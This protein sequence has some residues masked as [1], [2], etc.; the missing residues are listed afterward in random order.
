MM[1]YDVSSIRLLNDTG[2]SSTDK[3][4]YDPTLTGTVSSGTG[5]SSGMSGGYGGFG[6]LH[7]QFDHNGD[8][9]GDGSVIVNGTSFQYDPRTTDPGLYFYAGSVNFKQRV[10]E[11]NYYNQLVSTGPW[12]D[13]G[14]TLET[15]ASGEIQLRDNN[16]NILV[17]Q[18]NFNF[19]SVEVG[20]TL[21]RTFTIDNL[22]SPMDPAAILRLKTND[23]Q[24]PPGYSITKAYASTVSPGQQTSFTI[25]V[26]TSTAGPKWGT[27]S[28]K[29][30]DG[31]ENP[32]T[33]K[34]TADVLSRDPEIDIQLASSGQ[35]IVD[36]TGSLSFGSTEIGTPVQRQIRI[37]NQGNSPLSLGVPSVGSGFSITSFVPSS[38]PANSSVLVTLQM[39]AGAIGSLDVP[40][41]IT[42]NDSDENPYNFSLK[43]TITNV[44]PP[45]VDNFALLQDNGVSATDRITTDPRLSGTVRGAFQGGTVRVEFDHYRTGNINGSLSISNSGDSFT[46]DPRTTDNRLADVSGR[47]TL[48]YRVVHLNAQ[49]ETISTGNWVDFSLVLDGIASTAGLTLNNFGLVRDTGSSLIDRTTTDPT[50]R[51]TLSGDRAGGKVRLEFDQQ[52]NGTVTKYVEFPADSNQVQ[53]DPRSGDPSLIGR[54]GPVDLRYRLTKLDAVGNTLSSS[55]WINF[56]YQLDTLP[57]SKVEVRNLRL[58]NDT[59]TSATDRITS[60]PTL[61]GNLFDTAATPIDTTYT[62]V[63]FD[64]NGDG[65]VDG[66]VL[67]DNLS[68]FTYRPQGLSYNSHTLRVRSAS[69]RVEFASYLLGPWSEI[70][71]QLFAPPAPVIESLALVSDTGVSSTDKITDNP[72]IVGTVKLEERPVSD[73]LVYIDHDGNG[74]SEGTAIT[75]RFG[76]FTYRPRNLKPGAVQLTLTT[77]YWDSNLNSTVYAKP[78]QFQYTY[79]AT[80]LPKIDWLD[81]AIDDGSDRLDRSTSQSL[82]VGQ[83]STSAIYA[84]VQIEFD[85]DNNGS[86]DGVGFSDAAG[87][88]VYRPF[89]LAP[90]A[91]TLKARTKVWDIDQVQWV[92]GDWSQTQFTLVAS[93]SSSLAI[94][95]LALRR[96]TGSNTSDRITSEATLVGQIRQSNSTAAVSVF[97]LANKRVEFDENGDDQVDGYTFTEDNGKFTYTPKSLSSGAKSFRART[98][99]WNTVSNQGELS[100]WSTFAF[101]LQPDS[102]VAP[103]V[104]SLALLSDSGTSATDRITRHPGLLGTVQLPPGATTAMLEV[105]LNSDGIADFL[106]TTQADGTFLVQPNY[107]TF[108]PKTVAVR[109]FVDSSSSTSRVYSPWQSFNY[110]YSDLPSEPASLTQLAWT[111]ATLKNSPILT[112]KVIDDSSVANVK[113][114]IDLNNDGVAEAVVTTDAQGKFQYNY[115]PASSAAQ[116]SV[117]L[118]LR[119]VQAIDGQA[120]QISA[121]STQ[122]FANPAPTPPSPATLGSWGLA[123]DDG[124]SSTDRISTD[125]T[126]RGTINAG[127]NAGSIAEQLI[128][129][130]HDGDGKPDGSTLTDTQGKFTYP[131]NLA[132]G[133][134]NIATRLVSFDPDLGLITGAW[135]QLVV[136]QS[137]LVETKIATL[138]LVSDTGTVNDG[139]TANPAVQGTLTGPSVAQV[140]I[141]VD[142]NGD[143]SPDGQTTTNAAG[144]FSYTPAT[145]SAEGFVQATAWIARGGSPT[146]STAKTYRFVYSPAPNGNSAQALV[147]QL[148]SFDSAWQS[149]NTTLQQSL[150]AAQKSLRSSL[151]TADATYRT[152]VSAAY[153]L[154]QS[155]R[156]STLSAYRDSL[157]SAEFQLGTA[158]SSAEAT[159][160]NQTSGQTSGTDPLFV[161]PITPPEDALVIPND[162]DQPAPPQYIGIDAGQTLDV[163]SHPS[164]TQLYAIADSR[165]TTAYAAAEAAYQ[166]RLAQA[167]GKAAQSQGTAFQRF[168]SSVA[169]ARNIK[170]SATQNLQHPDIDLAAASR[171]SATQAQAKQDTKSAAAIAAEKQFTDTAVTLNY[172]RTD[173]INLAQ[174]DRESRIRAAWNAFN[175]DFMYSYGNSSMLQMLTKRRDDALQ[176]AHRIYIRTLADAEYDYTTKLAEAT[177]TRDVSIATSGYDYESAAASFSKLV[178]DLVAVVEHWKQ[179]QK[180]LAA[181]NEQKEIALAAES[182]ALAEA[183]TK[184]NSAVAQIEAAYERQ[185]SEIAADEENVKTKGAVAVSL[186]T[187]FAKFVDSPAA[188]LQLSYAEADR[189][190][191]DS[192]AGSKAQRD[193]KT[194]TEKRDAALYAASQAKQH[195]YRVAEANRVEAMATADKQKQLRTEANDAFKQLDLDR[196]LTT[197]NQQV[198]DATNKRDHA[199]NLANAS[200][201]FT[202]AAAVQKKAYSYALAAPAAFSLVFPYDKSSYYGQASAQATYQFE[203]AMIEVDRN[204]RYAQANN[205]FDQIAKQARS[206]AL[207]T[208]EN[209]TQDHNTRALLIQYSTTYDKLIAD[210]VAAR[211]N[212][213]TTSAT[214][215]NRNVLT[216]LDGT[217]QEIS[218]LD[219]TYSTEVAQADR[220][221]NLSKV[222]AKATKTVETYQTYRD[223]TRSFATSLGTPWGNLHLKQAEAQTQRQTLQ[224]DA[225]LTQTQEDNRSLETLTNQFLQ[226]TKSLID[227]QQSGTLGF[228]SS[229]LGSLADY[230]S[231]TNRESSSFFG[232]QATLN[233]TF[234]IAI[235]QAYAVWKSRLAEIR[236]DKTI[237]DAAAQ[238]AYLLKDADAKATVEPAYAAARR[239]WAIA[240]A[241]YSANEIN[242]TQWQQAKTAY[243][244]AIAAADRQLA[245]LLAPE[246]LAKRTS[247]G[248]AIRVR[249][250]DT[251]KAEETW[252]KSTTTAY[253][254]WVKNSGTQTTTTAT[255]FQNLGSTFVTS[256][257]QQSVTTST[258]LENAEKAFVQSTSS[259]QATW[260]TQLT[261]NANTFQTAQAGIEGDWLIGKIDARADYEQTLANNHFQRKELVYQNS[262]SDLALLQKAVAQGDA[263]KYTQRRTAYQARATAWKSHALSLTTTLNTTDATWIDSSTTTDLALVRGSTNATAQ[264]NIQQATANSSL[265]RDISQADLQRSRDEVGVSI[266]TRLETAQAE[267]A[268]ALRLQTALVVLATAR[269]AALKQKHIDQYTAAANSASDQA[270]QTATQT[271]NSSAK[272]SKVTLAEKLGDIAIAAATKSGE[273]LANQVTSWNSA[274]QSYT[275]QDN[276]IRSSY[277]TAINSL[278]V[279]YTQGIAAA[280]SLADSA[281]ATAYRD[282]LLASGLA[283]VGWVTTFANADATRSGAQAAAQG[284][285]VSGQV[286]AGRS[287]L[288]WTCGTAGTANATGSWAAQYAPART[289][290]ISATAMA[291][292]GR[293]IASWQDRTLR[294]NQRATADVQFIQAIATPETQLEVATTQRENQTATASTN[295]SNDLSSDL[296]TSGANIQ[297]TS[298]AIE[299]SSAV[300]A[301][302]AWKVYQVAL[303]GLDAGAAT[304]T[305]D[306]A[307]QDALA[308]VTRNSR[309]AYANLTYTEGV[310]QI[311]SVADAITD[312][313]Q[314]GKTY[315]TNIA[316][317]EK[318][319]TDT[320]APIIAARTLL[321]TQADND[322]RKAVTTADNRWRNDTARA[323]GNQTTGDLVARGNVRRTLANG[324]NLVADKSQASIAELKAQWWQGELPNYLQWSVDVGA[325]ETTYTNSITAN[326]LSRATGVKNAGVSYASTVGAAIQTYETTTAA[327][328]A[329]YLS[330]VMSSGETAAEAK[331][332]AG[333]DKEIAL[334]NADLQKQLTGNETA[335]ATAV[336]HANSAYDT[337]TTNAD[338]VLKS[339]KQTALSQ[340]NSALAQSSKD[341]D[342]AIAGAESTYD[343]LVAALDAQYGSASSNGDTGIEG[344]R[345][346][347]AI[348]TRDAQYYASRDTSWAGTLSGSA[349]IG[350]TPWTLKAIAAANARA[351]YSTSRASSQAAHDAALLSAM[352]DWQTSNRTSTLSLLL[353]EGQ[354]REAYNKATATVYAN[355][356]MGAGNLLGDKPA[357]TGWSVGENGNSTEASNPRAVGWLGIAFWADDETGE[358]VAIRGN[359]NLKTDQTP[360]PTDARK[361]NSANDISDESRVKE[362]EPYLAALYGREGLILLKAFRESGA[363]VRFAWHWD[364]GL[365]MQGGSDLEGNWYN[366]DIVIDDTLSP[367]EKAE[368]L[369]RQLIEASGYSGVRAKLGFGLKITR[370][371]SDRY[372]ASIAQGCKNAVPIVEGMAKAYLEGIALVSVGADIVVT[373][374]EL[375]ENQNPWALIGV[376]PLIPSNIRN[377]SGNLVLRAGNGISVKVSESISGVLSRLSKAQLDELT[378]KL[379]KAKTDNEAQQILE[380]FAKLADN[381]PISV[382][383]SATK[384]FKVPNAAHPKIQS[385]LSELHK[386]FVSEGGTIDRIPGA[387]VNAAGERIYGRYIQVL[388]PDGT[389]RHRIEL[390]DRAGLDT[391]VHELLHFEQ[392]TKTTGLMNKSLEDAI[393]RDV[394]LKMLDLGF[395]LQ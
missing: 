171:Q 84:N 126:L 236:R 267:V 300:D 150:T 166:N 140:L 81:I 281:T 175:Q 326:T 393:E 62:L 185:N 63:Q 96:D 127:S 279:P 64:H 262:P 69:Y 227:S 197:Y 353:A 341:K 316:Q 2:I 162:A 105:D 212:S 194:A 177:K 286:Q 80:P 365:W 336:N 222:T 20:A 25:T 191:T 21:S 108:G 287:S 72:T 93:P 231:G 335:Y 137:A 188:Q 292:A 132:V 394:F 15:A 159:F 200:Y 230:V 58:A 208:S 235:S 103:P 92:A 19:G 214:E 149:A 157:R 221:E 46:Y 152:E 368:Q 182:R 99:S 76:N 48:R 294:D 111:P 289:A 373:T 371:D 88:I 142:V 290:M 198:R 124:A 129:F 47:W 125:L 313:G 78:I 174:R 65:L 44:A 337:A 345:R 41:S 42:S 75:D 349:T 296:D 272:S 37:A 107:T 98:R 250:I 232:G 117:T 218:T 258:A 138:G 309:V 145:P 317:D 324:S 297:S 35:T 252:T 226:Q 97:G 27:F 135:S 395:V 301:A 321:Y 57:A 156:L 260:L 389:I 229:A 118:R 323:W 327:A 49:G 13:F 59:G 202:V 366:P 66:S 33:L 89:G 273:N 122:T 7:V 50:I 28:F 223:R 1:A 9:V 217:L 83:L 360:N 67:T 160:A 362:L 242:N 169:Q 328:R 295:T 325:I 340:L 307:Y 238:K 116:S 34:F 151:Q 74:T 228:I 234:Q 244:N 91:V 26:D 369:M 377:S 255:Q 130:D 285:W 211:A 181:Y 190:A 187:P 54:V 284:A 280:D 55:R 253:V 219:K 306:K 134:H 102:T 155:T 161:W 385:K 312:F 94:D 147:T 270:I 141:F 358:S 204:N 241:K 164:V 247:E 346:Q 112:G 172:N 275:T 240:S 382:F 333:R 121:W 370:E 314:I 372:R 144:A 268:H 109:S 192:K 131:L 256:T 114:E 186:L 128:Q 388:A 153:S 17:N 148:A 225:L 320:A 136:T 350:N 6:V 330:S 355:W 319:Y 318:S 245:E 384:R 278:T 303:A 3:I 381:A 322:L 201:D 342:T 38:I 29:N 113:V 173:V 269:G 359:S 39:N 139:S 210:I 51:A 43:G 357:G 206:E 376:L 207:T 120:A 24:L 73:Y 288:L 87:A 386:N 189:T 90:G 215:M 203:V 332:K 14:F 133:Q 361:V 40:F 338:A 30:S 299:K 329:Q 61:T 343:Q 246:Q 380:Q 31:D 310:A 266:D 95:S 261:A 352:N 363:N 8:G 274:S 364:W 233:Q 311:G 163:A 36:N 183:D 282:A 334:A 18:T 254:D 170:A 239:D 209:E 383:N 264:A 5:G 82:I 100:P 248:E 367:P 184:Y 375:Y 257:A 216:D 387:P 22:A 119:T 193:R 179:N 315:V 56:A 165:T 176:E 265:Q 213:Q 123:N 378:A 390:Y 291:D 71:L 293:Q 283:D 178:R 23:I 195:A 70:S 356:E 11:Y 379:A 243:D 104:A 374:N 205:Q 308:Q 348:S 146:D 85:H 347:A 115:V 224:K 271:Y 305:V 167:A 45:Y 168:A 392:A 68:V 86:V 304:T 237:S 52:G 298:A 339:T 180:I 10:L 263:T 101:T 331:L 249:E 259:A 60:D 16:Q 277:T 79:V 354:S 276:T 196:S 220:T 199:H 251:A 143:G 106:T 158:L 391:R 351:A 12:T 53:Y 32:F 4:T 302:K 344:A 110:S 154:F 77:A